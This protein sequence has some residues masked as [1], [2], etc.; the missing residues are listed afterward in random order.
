MRRHGPVLGD[1]DAVRDIAQSLAEGL[2]LHV[3]D[4][5]RRLPDAVI[6]LQLDEPSLPA[7]LRGSVPTPS[8]WGRVGAVDESTA[9]QVLGLVLDAAR[10]AGALPL[11]HCCAASLPLALVRRA[12]AA[13]VSLDA[14]LLRPADDDAVGAALDEGTGLVLG[15]DPVSEPTDSVRAVQQVRRRLGIDGEQFARAVALSPACGLA[16]ASP[17]A[18]LDALAHV[19]AAAALLRDEL[20]LS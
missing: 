15:V 18:A 14:G 8:G 9:E 3:A 2:A 10:A 6:M 20:E 1:Q 13:A 17:G 11:V 5:R 16:A 12:G 19:R 4:V 7:V